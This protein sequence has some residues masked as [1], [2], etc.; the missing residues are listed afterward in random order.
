MNMEIKARHENGFPG[1]FRMKSPLTQTYISI[2]VVSIA[3][4]WIFKDLPIIKHLL[5]QNLPW[6]LDVIINVL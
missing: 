3:L 6:E 5:C 2:L 4:V 1:C